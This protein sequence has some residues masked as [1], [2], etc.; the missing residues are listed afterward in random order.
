MFHAV[1]QGPRF[2]PSCAFPIFS[3]F[4][5]LSMSLLSSTCDSRWGERGSG[6]SHGISRARSESG[7]H[8]FCP[9]FIGQNFL[10]AHMIVRGS[11]KYTPPTCSEDNVW[12]LLHRDSQFT[13]CPPLVC[14]GTR[15][16]SSL[17]IRELP[18]VLPSLAI[19]HQTS[20]THTPMALVLSIIKLQVRLFWAKPGP[21]E[22]T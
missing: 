21:R 5:E 22:K 9:L 13:F 15:T 16:S 14:S 18:L 10:L 11:G 1:I 20:N 2:P 6:G 19:P 7:K 8:H 4:S 3:G 12:S 17:K